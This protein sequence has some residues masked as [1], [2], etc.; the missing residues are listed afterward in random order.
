MNTRLLAVGLA[1]GAV[2]AAPA[3]AQVSC[4]FD[5]PAY[6]TGAL[7]GQGAWSVWPSD[8]PASFAQVVTN[9]RRAGAQ[10]A[11]VSAQELSGDAMQGAA[12]RSA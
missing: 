1:A 4:G 7:A 6:H 8:S 11:R 5:P 3:S 10:A 12:G 9:P 2:L